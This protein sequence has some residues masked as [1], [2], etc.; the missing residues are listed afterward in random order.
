MCYLMVGFEKIKYDAQNFYYKYIATLIQLKF[1]IRLHSACPKSIIELRPYKMYPIS[2]G[3]KIHTIKCPRRNKS[4]RCQLHTRAYK[5]HTKT[6]FQFYLLSFRLG[7]YNLSHARM[8]SFRFLKTCFGLSSMSQLIPFN[9][10]IYPSTFFSS[11][12]K[13]YR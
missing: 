5:L 2:L 9:S 10:F 6:H 3:Y 11:L 7:Q 4:Q 13:I 8:S 12:Q 1:Y